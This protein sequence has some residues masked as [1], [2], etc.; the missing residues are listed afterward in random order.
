MVSFRTDEANESVPCCVLLFFLQQV[1]NETKSTSHK[2][3]E[4]YGQVETTSIA[5]TPFKTQEDDITKIGAL[6][7]VPTTKA[8]VKGNE[9]SGQR[10]M[11]LLGADVWI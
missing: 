4:N 10:I 2:T 9:L 7:V 6:P 11:A 1:N 5:D 3:T 8:E